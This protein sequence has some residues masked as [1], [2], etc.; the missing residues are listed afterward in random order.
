[1]PQKANP[2]RVAFGGLIQ[3][4]DD[5]YPVPQCAGAAQKRSRGGVRAIT[6]VGEGE[7]GGYWG[8]G[9]GADSCDMFSSVASHH[10]SVRR[11]SVPSI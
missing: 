4:G 2:A 1:M 6:P 9:E 11:N 10:R 7:R 8:G 5:R 3:V